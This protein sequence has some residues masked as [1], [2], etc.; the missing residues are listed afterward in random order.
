MAIKK[1]LPKKLSK[2]KTLGKKKLAKKKPKVP[3]RNP[4]K[5]TAKDAKILANLPIRE[6]HPD[7]FK[8]ALTR[9]AED[10]AYR[11]KAIRNPAVVVRDFDLSLK[12]LSALRGVAVM[13]GADIKQVD[14][15]SAA[16]I[17]LHAGMENMD[18]DV[19]CCSCCCCCCGET[20][21][22]SSF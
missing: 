5:L 21:V 14:R 1:K 8:Q 20:A 15:L 22:E 18:I 17:D 19:S 16:A 11:R 12:E 4:R 7:Q 9:L 13:S 6:S 10:Q 2:K 3:E